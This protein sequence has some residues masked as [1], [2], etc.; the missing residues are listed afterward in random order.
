MKHYDWN[1]A[2]EA[3]KN[4]PEKEQEELFLKQCVEAFLFVGSQLDEITQVFA[5]QLAKPG[6]KDRAMAAE[7][8]INYL[9]QNRKYEYDHFG[10]KYSMRWNYF[11]AD[12]LIIVAELV[13]AITKDEKETVDKIF[14]K[15]LIMGDSNTGDQ[16]AFNTARFAYWILST[17][18]RAKYYDT[19]LKYIKKSHTGNDDLQRSI[20]IM[21]AM[22]EMKDLKHLK[23]HNINEMVLMIKEVNSK[24]TP[25]QPGN[26]DGSN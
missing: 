7:Q 20:D 11:Y 24:N 22:E 2:Y 14:E 26:G 6:N 19:F 1:Q 16:V 12:S 3:R 13:D 4:L 18:D 5:T 25:N 17:G 21:D 10:E 9:Y 15:L 8:I 23:Q